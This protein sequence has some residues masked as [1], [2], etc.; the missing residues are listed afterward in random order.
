MNSNKLDQE[1]KQ[2]SAG[3]MTVTLLNALDFVIPGSYHNSTSLRDMV[4]SQGSQPMAIRQT[5]IT[6]EAERLYAEDEGA[7]KAVQL[8]KLTDQADKAVAAAALA[9][10]IGSRFGALSFL[11]K[12]T[13]KAD[14]VQTIDLCLKVT[15]EAMAYLSLHG[16]SLSGVGDWAKMVTQADRYSNESA[17]RLA[18]IIGV[19]GLIPLGPDFVSKVT[20]TLGG[21]SMGWGNNALFKQISGFLP[22]E[23]EEE[24]GAFIQ[25]TFQA[26]TAPI[27]GFIEKTGLTREKAVGQLKS[28]T[29]FSDDK[30]DYAAAFLDASTSY[31][32]Q[33]GVQTVAR[34]FVGKAIERVDQGAIR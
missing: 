11:T 6:N 20:D 1:L 29:D 21:T 17:L 14:T 2:L 25:T 26:A 27:K 28:F 31:M 12:F 4:Q 15:V 32:S 9:N 19:D 10:K 5:N 18:A 24:K 16:M 34:H 23:S 33:T 7:Q 30:L 13:P 8:Y 22:G 3:G